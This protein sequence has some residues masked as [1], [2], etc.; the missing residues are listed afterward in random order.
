M[1]KVKGTAHTDDFSAGQLTPRYHDRRGPR[2]AVANRTF[3]ADAPDGK[4]AHLLYTDLTGEVVLLAAID[5]DGGPTISIDDPRALLAPEELARRGLDPDASGDILLSDPKAAVLMLNAAL[6]FDNPHF[7]RISAMAIKI[8][9]QRITEL[10]SDIDYQSSAWFDAVPRC[11]EV[12]QMREAATN[13]LSP[14]RVVGVNY[15]ESEPNCF[16]VLVV[17]E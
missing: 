2:A 6:A 1:A 14:R 11:G 16:R 12:I 9:L 15:V 8:D 4:A 5:R 7:S 3:A 10:D 13:V 17:V